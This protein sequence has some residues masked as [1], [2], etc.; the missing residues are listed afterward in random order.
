MFTPVC[1]TKTLD[2]VPTCPPDL[3][4]FCHD[5][6]SPALHGVIFLLVSVHG[7]IPWHRA[8]K[9]YQSSINIFFSV[10]TCR[11]WMLLQCKGREFQAKERAR[12][13]VLQKEGA[14]RVWGAQRRPVSQRKGPRKWGQAGRQ[15][16][17]VAGSPRRWRLAYTFTINHHDYSFL[18]PLYCVY[19]FTLPSFSAPI[20]IIFFFYS[21]FFG[22][23]FF[24]LLDF[25]V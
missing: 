1:G 8:G 6:H 22:C 18:D 25:N 11:Q 24:S 13:K 20:F 19:F 7:C 5:I 23:T 14:W 4:F 12:A 17:R 9:H 2:L 3:I 16:W 15:D 10:Q 21:A